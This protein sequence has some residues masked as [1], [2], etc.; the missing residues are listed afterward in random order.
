MA[1]RKSQS[2]V[3]RFLLT[4]GIWLILIE[5]VL[6]SPAWTF[7]PL[8]VEQ[9]GGTV[10][11][12]MGVICAIGAAMVVLGGAQFLGR[13]ACLGIAATILVGH[14]LLDPMWPVTDP[15]Q[16]GAPWWAPLHS[17][18]GYGLAP[19]Y[20]VFLYPLLPW[21]G[22]MLLGYGTAGL[23]EQPLARRN[24]LLV[25][26]G[27]GATTVFLILRA[28]GIYG[29][30]NPWSGGAGP[31]RTLIDFINTTK[32]PPSLLFLLMTL[33]PAAIVCSFADRMPNAV[34]QRLVTF[35][36]APFAF[37]VAHLYLIHM[38]AV[39]L[40]VLQGFEPHQ[41]MTDLFFFPKGYGIGLSGVYIVWL[42]VIATLFPLCRSIA[43]L[44]ARRRE[45]WLS[46]L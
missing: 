34:R 10:L 45:W 12:R 22:V 3:G 44:K 37:Y 7:A 28:A 17:Q 20:V 36:R 40:G 9:A 5:A 33:G 6:I 38:I 24:R 46:Y 14:N 4:R 32:Y 15:F 11:I 18:A 2:E 16:P 13:R 1:A 39:V 43:L 29:D 23:F 21:T 27:A 30:P 8:G 41:M 19:F 42:L 35:G 31:M 26:C 25:T